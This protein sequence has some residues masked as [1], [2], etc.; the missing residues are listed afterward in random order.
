MSCIIIGN[1]TSVLIIS[2]LCLIVFSCYGL[3]IIT[4][5]LVFLSFACLLRSCSYEELG[6][7]GFHSRLGLIW[8]G[9]RSPAKRICRTLDVARQYRPENRI[10]TAI[11]AGK[12]GRKENKSP[13]PTQ[14]SIGGEFSLIKGVSRRSPLARKDTDLLPRAACS[15]AKLY[16]YIYIYIYIHI[17]IY[18]CNSM[19]YYSVSLASLAAYRPHRLESTTLSER[20]AASRNNNHH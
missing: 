9:H 6:F 15:K 11:F 3:F 5:L 17:Y 2:C 12:K 20:F 8:V 13:W 14:V 16:I 1:A 18:I 7:G 10:V 19:V 4:V